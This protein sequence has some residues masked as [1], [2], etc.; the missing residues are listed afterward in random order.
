[1]AI[2]IRLSRR[3]FC[4]GSPVVL[5]NQLSLPLCSVRHIQSTVPS[6][7]AGWT[8]QTHIGVFTMVSLNSPCGI[9]GRRADYF[10]LWPIRMYSNLQ[11]IISCPEWSTKTIP[12]KIGVYHGDPLSVVIFNTVMCTLADSFVNL[13]HLG[14]NFS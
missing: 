8:W 11:A 13:H 2:W 3:P 12:L 7:F 4:Q 9:M 10:T 5:S 14:Y 1:M 6:Q